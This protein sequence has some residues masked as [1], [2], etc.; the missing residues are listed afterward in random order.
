MLDDA[1]RQAAR[2]AIES[3]FMLRDEE[4]DSQLSKLAQSAASHQDADDFAKVA[5]RLRL[6]CEHDLFER[7]HIVWMALKR[8]HQDIDNTQTP[9]LLK[10][11]CQDLHLFMKDA[12]VNLANQIGR[13][14]E[15]LAP[16]FRGPDPL[17]AAWLR[18]LLRL[19]EERQL[20][21][22]ESYVNSRRSS[23]RRR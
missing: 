13:Y 16:A 2:G 21:A 23:L 9:Q 12:S 8:A 11:L 6:A 4:L 15:P 14:S 22:M 7:A 3:R 19:A 17:D 5:V 10:D 1:I 18:R 20:K